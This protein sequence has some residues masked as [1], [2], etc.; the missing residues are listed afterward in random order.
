MQISRYSDLVKN[1]QSGNMPAIKIRNRASDVYVTYDSNVT[2]LD[3]IAA[4]MYGDDTLYWLIL[5]G[6]PQYYSEFDI[7]KNAIIRIPMPLQDVMSEF[8]VK[9]K[10][11]QIT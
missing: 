11:N 1:G 6:N 7:P 8:L 3:R 9:V 10:D 5:L 2:R 4:D